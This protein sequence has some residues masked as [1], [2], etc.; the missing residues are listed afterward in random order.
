MIGESNNVGR[1]VK[2]LEFRSIKAVM[3]P[4][5][6]IPDLL[7]ARARAGGED[8]RGQL[9]ERYCNYLRFMA[10]A[11]ISQPLRARLDA[12]DLVQETFLKAYRE[13]AGFLGSTEPELVAWLRQT[14]VHTL[15]DQVKRHRAQCR[16]YRR[17][18]RLEA[19]LDRS[20]LE[21]QQRLAASLSSPSSHAMRREQA[22]LLADALA[23]LPDDYREVFVL[24]ILE[25]VPVEEIAARMGRSVNAVRKLWTRAMLALERALEDSS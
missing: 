5:S 9:L 7:L 11:L 10:R 20:S 25:H 14:L 19:L 18:E 12:S 16:D 1:I 2:S 22:V 23:T 3:S 6:S 4:S 15:A 13:F 17:E 24:R 8:A 21:I